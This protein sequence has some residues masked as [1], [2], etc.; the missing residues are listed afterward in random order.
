MRALM[1]KRGLPRDARGHQCQ[2]SATRVGEGVESQH[3]ADYATHRACEYRSV[4]D[5]LVWGFT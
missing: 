5:G 1:R 2:V 4:N 3:T